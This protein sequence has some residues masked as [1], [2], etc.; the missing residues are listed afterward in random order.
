MGYDSLCRTPEDSMLTVSPFRA[1]LG[2]Q[3][4]FRGSRKIKT[5]R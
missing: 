5:P 4:V 2:F 1:E 3:R